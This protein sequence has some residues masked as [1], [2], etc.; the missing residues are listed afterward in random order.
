VHLRRRVRADRA[1]D[2]AGVHAVDRRLSGRID[3]QDDEHGGAVERL[4]ERRRESLGPCVAVRLEHR[5]DPA[6][7]IRGVRRVEK[8]AELGR[9]MSVVVDDDDAVR[10]ALDLE[11]PPDALELGE[12]LPDPLRGHVEFAPHRGGGERVVHVV[13]PRHVE[14]DLPQVQKG[15]SSGTLRAA[16]RLPSD[17]ENAA[18]VGRVEF[19]DNSVQSG[20]GTVSL[21]ATVANAD[22]HFWPGQLVNVRLVL[23]T[24]KAAVLIPSQAAQI[25]QQGPFVYVVKA[26]E[27]AELRFVKLGQTHGDHVVVMEG[28]SVHERVVVTGQMLVRPGIK[29]QVATGSRPGSAANASNKMNGVAGEGQ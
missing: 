9:M 21:R 16:V 10:F 7:R 13:Q 29:V 22:Q 1:G 11:P 5:D 19:L 25:S 4:A 8:R 15:M 3:W 6:L 20:S 23:A 2:E 18:R 24:E 26:D 28:I 12:P 17:A 27:T 14:R